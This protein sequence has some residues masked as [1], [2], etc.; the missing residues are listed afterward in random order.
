LKDEVN[1]IDYVIISDDDNNYYL[2]SN[3]SYFK[4]YIFEDGT[5]RIVGPKGLAP[6][7]YNIVKGSSKDTMD[8]DSEESTDIDNILMDFDSDTNGGNG[9]E[10]MGP[11]S[12]NGSI[13]HNDLS[14]IS[15][16]VLEYIIHSSANVIVIFYSLFI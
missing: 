14:V 8:K 7:P 15:Y 13:G 10:G 2:Y 12:I 4:Y 6:N 1:L 9:F 11:D 3:Y 16:S 5:D